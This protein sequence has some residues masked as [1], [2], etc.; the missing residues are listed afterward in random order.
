M[1][2]RADPKKDSEYLPCRN[3]THTWP[4]KIP[5][6]R[7]ASK[8]LAEFSAAWFAFSSDP[9]IFMMKF[10]WSH[11]MTAV[12]SSKYWGVEAIFVTWRVSTVEQV[13]KKQVEKE[14]VRDTVEN[15][16]EHRKILSTKS[17][18]EFQVQNVSF[19]LTTLY[20]TVISKSIQLEQTS[21][22]KLSVKLRRRSC[23]C[24]TTW[25]RS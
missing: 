18:A 8:T 10:W 11:R 14:K 25:A 7:A 4:T 17:K 12:L 15:E 20:A 1:R 9:S 5:L 16:S 24:Y 13:T 6:R 19:Q 2:P 3:R 22:R 21:D 23:C